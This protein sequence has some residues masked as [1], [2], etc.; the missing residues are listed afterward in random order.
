MRR[1]DQHG[2]TLELETSAAGIRLTLDSM[3]ELSGYINE[4]A[5]SATLIHPDLS[6]EEWTLSQTAPGRYEIAIPL[7][8]GTRK[9]AGESYH[10]QT[11]LK[12][13]GKTLESQSRSIMTRYS[14]ELRIRPT[15]ETLLRQLAELTG[16]GYDV[17]ASDIADWQASRLARKAIPLWS[18]LLTLAAML[19]VFDVLLRRVEIF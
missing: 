5:G 6:K 7:M 16:G 17:S 19:F 4:A 18:W 13:G 9:S 15:N 11:E 8:S 1:S 14:D 2:S 12:L 3:D 10:L